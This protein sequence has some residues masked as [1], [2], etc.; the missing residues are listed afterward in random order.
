M[1]DEN[2]KNKN[3]V[4]AIIIENNM[5]TEFIAANSLNLRNPMAELVDKQIRGKAQCL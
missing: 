5:M 1:N 2:F 4:K 3:V